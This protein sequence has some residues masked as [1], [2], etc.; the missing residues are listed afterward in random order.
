MEPICALLESSSGSKGERSFL[1]NFAAGGLCGAVSSAIMC[2]ADV[3]KVRMQA[4]VFP[5]RNPVHAISS[6]ARDEGECQPRINVYGSN[7]AQVCSQ[8][9]VPLPPSPVF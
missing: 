3:A 7:D 4:N 6:I 2:P 9:Q 5:Y 1:L 8:S